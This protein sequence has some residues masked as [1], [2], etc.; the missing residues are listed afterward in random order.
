MVK[1]L[2]DESKLFTWVELKEADTF[3]PRDLETYPL[4]GNKLVITP[5]AQALWKEISTNLQKKPA[6]EWYFLLIS[7]CYGSGKSAALKMCA[8]ALQQKWNMRQ[9]DRPVVYYRQPISQCQPME[10]CCASFFFF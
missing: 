3:S 4:F 8:C 5:G 7:G 9:L 2:E 10:G 6:P 1:L